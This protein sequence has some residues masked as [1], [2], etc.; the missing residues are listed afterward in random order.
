MT[1]KI[2]ISFGR[3]HEVFRKLPNSQYNNY[4]ISSMK[5]SMLQVHFLVLLATTIVLSLTNFDRCVENGILL[6]KSICLPSTY[7]QLT[8]IKL[9]KPRVRLL[10]LIKLDKKSRLLLKE[11][12]QIKVK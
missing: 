8:Q 5:F 6:T 9:V 7:K 12:K 1:E 10:S 3:G 4:Y 11:R 2:N